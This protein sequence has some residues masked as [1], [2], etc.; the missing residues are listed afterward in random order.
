ME[1]A[2]ASNTPT[3]AVDSVS[4]EAPTDVPSGSGLSVTEAIETKLRKGLSP[5]SLKIINQSD[6]HKHHVAMHGV[7][8]T[9]ET[10]FRIEVV[11][12]MFAGLGLVKRHRV[13]FE[14]LKEEMDGPVHALSLDTKAPEEV[15]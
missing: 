12:D 7:P 9:G 14:L 11:S 5:Q 4:T 3:P 10:H 8:Q 6:Q 15:N 2:P 13:V 1:S